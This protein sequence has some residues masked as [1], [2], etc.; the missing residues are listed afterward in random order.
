MA[1]PVPVLHSSFMRAGLRH[2]GT[3]RERLAVCGEADAPVAMGIFTRLKAGNWQTF[4]PSQF[5]LGPFLI[6]DGIGIETLL[7]GLTGRLPGFPVVTSLTQVDSQFVRPPGTSGTVRS[8]PYIDTAWVDVVGTFDD[9]WSAR[10]KNLRHNVKRQIAKL[11]ESRTSTALEVVEQPRDV[12]RAVAE[13]ARLESAGWKAGEGTAVQAGT[14]QGNFYKAMLE[15][16]CA[17]GQGRIYAYRIGDR[18]AAVD[19]CVEQGDV[20]VVLKTAYDEAQKS[21]SP[22]TLMRHEYF[23]RIFDEGRL[24]RI[25]FYGRVMEWHTRWTD[26]RRPLVHVNHYRWL[27][28][29]RMRERSNPAATSLTT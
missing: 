17:D 29:K 23:R 13:Y 8:I 20:L 21:V 7:P 22:A 6:R 25:E 26:R 9:Y 3:G 4:Q 11:A 5:P 18:I 12:A 2:F 16:F 19:L 27:W 10:G 24:R 1:A 28:M 14:P 15:A